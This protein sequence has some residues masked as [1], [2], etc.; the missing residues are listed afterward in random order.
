MDTELPSGTPAHL[1]TTAGAA[2][3]LVVVPDIWGLR[4]LFTDMCDDLAART[5]WSVGTFELFPDRDLPGEKE[6]DAGPTRFAAVPDLSDD[7]VLG[8]A[9]AT[10]DALGCDDVGLIGFCIGGMYAL[11]ASAT[12]RFDR[13]GA[14]YGMIH[15]P[16]TWH[17]PEQGEPLEAL[18]RRGGTD[19]VE[20]VG[21][22]D[23]YTPPEHVRELRDAGVEVLLYEGA[24]HGFVH[25]PSRPTHRAEDAADAWQRVLSFLADGPPA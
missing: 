12:G 16:E 9:V 11:K 21:S 18:A 6:P 23:G 25:D 5:G 17:G 8:D 24:D 1:A 19:V 15:V 2:R 20:V 22:V 13:V 4:P 3:G 10:A 7:R 14:F